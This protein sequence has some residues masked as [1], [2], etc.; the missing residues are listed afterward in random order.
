VKIVKFRTSTSDQWGVLEKETIRSIEGSPFDDINLGGE[1]HSLNE[2]TLLAPISPLNKVPAIAANYGERDDRDGPGIFM[3]QPGTYQRHEGNIVFPRSCK[4]V[5]HEAEVGIV[6][7]KVARHV[8]EKEALDYVL[9][10]T[11]VNDVSARET[12]DISSY[13]E[14]PEIGAGITMR[15]KH[16]DTFCPIGPHIETEINDP[17]NLDIE[18]LVN[19]EISASGN[20]RDML[21]SISKLV[22]WVSEVMTLYPGDIIPSGCPETAE[23]NI[24]DRVEVKVEKIGSLVNTV[25]GDY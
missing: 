16:Y 8:D 1:I 22:S 25:I 21:F 24:G 17:G 10:Y 4:K 11:C 3:K 6:I 13:P 7:S 12:V 14:R 18:C 2:V 20:T 19:G 15:W 5:I 23:I 9:G